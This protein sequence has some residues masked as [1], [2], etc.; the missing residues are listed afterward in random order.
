MRANSLPAGG[1]SD[2]LV[3]AVDEIKTSPEKEILCRDIG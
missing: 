3:R 2:D 1:L